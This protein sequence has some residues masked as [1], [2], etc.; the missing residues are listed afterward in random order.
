VTDCAAE[1]NRFLTNTFYETNRIVL[2]GAQTR[3]VPHENRCHKDVRKSFAGNVGN[4]WLPF[5][6]NGGNDWLP[7]A[8]NGANDWLP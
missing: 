3:Y 4:D 5:A 6:G 8:G 2:R 7:F 1:I